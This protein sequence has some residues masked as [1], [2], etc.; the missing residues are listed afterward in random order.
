METERLNPW[1]GKLP[2]KNFSL[3]MFPDGTRWLRHFDQGHDG[4]IDPLGGETYIITEKQYMEAQKAFMTKDL[5]KIAKDL[6]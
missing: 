1:K 3:G 2:D 4:K 6:K 5:K